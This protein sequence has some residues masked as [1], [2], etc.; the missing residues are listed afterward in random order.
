MNKKSLSVKI[1][2]QIMKIGLYQVLLAIVFSAA[3]MAN[4]IDAQ[5]LLDKKITLKVE[6][7]QIKAIFS[8][9]EKQAEVKFMYTHELIKASRKVT[10]ISSDERLEDVLRKLL[11]PLN[12]SYEVNG[13]RILLTTIHKDKSEIRPNNQS[14]K[15]FA[16]EIK[17]KIIDETGN[18]MPG[19]NIAIK[20]TATG[21]TT[22]A[23]GDYTIN[24]PDE[25]QVL[26][27]S[28]IGYAT[29]EVIIGNQTILNITLITDIKTL[30]E[31]IV[32]GYGTQTQH[33]VTEAI[34]SVT[35]KDISGVAVTGLDQALQGKLAGVQV[36]Q[37]TGEPGGNV[38]IRIRG[39]GSI[40]N[41]NEP[42]YIVDGVPYGTNGPL[43]INPNDIERIDVLKDA[44][45]AAIYGSR[46]TN[47][48]VLVTTKRAKAGKIV[49][50][51]DAYAGIQS[52]Y[53]KLNLL[54]GT[55]FATLANENLMNANNETLA[56]DPN[57]PPK[58][59][60]GMNPAWSDPSKVLNTDWQNSVL[61]TAPIQSY[62]ISISGGTEKSR[63]LLSIG[64]F[65]QGGITKPSNYKRITARLN[66]DYEISQK[67]KVGITLNA[68]FEEKKSVISV[69]GGNTGNLGT[70]TS[71]ARMQ[72]TSLVTTDKNGYFG[73][74]NDGT[75]NTDST[76]YGYEGFSFPSKNGGRGGALAYL[77]GGLSNTAYLYQKSKS[78]LGK[79]QQLLMAGFIE[80][81]ILRGLKL[82][83]SL[84]YTLN[85]GYNTGFQ[86]KSPE[87]I[88]N[89][90]NNPLISFFNESTY[91]SNQWNWV[92]TLSYNKSF[93]KHNLGIIIG[94]DALKNNGRNISVNTSGVAD[95]QQYISGSDFGT[96]TAYGNPGQ[97]TLVSYISRLTYDYAGKYL[98][99]ANLRRDGSSNFGPGFKY[100]T[101][102]SASVGW[103]I[104]EE[105]F[106]KPLSFINELK[107]RASYGIVGN[108]NVRAFQYLNSYGN[109]G[110]N[111]QYTLGSAQNSVSAFFPL[112]IGVPSI[113]WEKSN[114]TNFGLDASFLNSK[115][116]ITADYYIKKISDM[117]GNFPVA[118]YTGVPGGSITKNGFSMENRGLELAI[119][120]NQKVGNV[121][122]S[123]N[124]NFSTLD[125]KVTKLTDNKTG[126]IA[127]DI[128]A[129]SGDGSA[130][131]RT[132]VGERIGNFYGYV[133]DGIIQ[134][135]SDLSLSG[136]PLDVTKPGDRKYKN[137]DTAK[138]INS[139]D[140]TIIGNG[141]PK[142][143]FG[144]SL[145]AEYKGFDVSVLLNGQS[146]VQIANQTR[147]WLYNMR[148]D[149]IQGGITNASADLVNS[150]KG[151]GTSNDLPRNSY[152][153]SP[154]NRLFSTF[155]IENGAF[156]R[157]RNI[158]L[159]YTLP[160]R[161]S[162]K[163]GMSRARVYLMAQNLYTFTKYTGYDPE[164]GSL[165]QDVLKT[166]VDFGRYP[167]PRMFTGGVNFQF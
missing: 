19:V 45:S 76:Y 146:G 90:G 93:D 84:N 4:D 135:S 160:E 108:Q 124:A 17:G 30:G 147:Y 20:G 138:A 75:Y 122:F 42:L 142:Y 27:F 22:D 53:K 144:F 39:V 105:E 88:Q 149:I 112:N 123:A 21:T 96:R 162:K 83:S 121:N 94:T 115:F 111:R 47:G 143:I 24:A 38:S 132:E 44:A 46:G 87:A 110:G 7:Q 2:F 129:G 167:I 150:W 11:I 70:L 136:M 67:L 165:N 41:S 92:N 89:R 120:Y 133:T 80:Y 32:V 51:F 10:L 3:T 54:N 74:N 157:V 125:N 29:Q 101:F 148:Y 34:G 139:K 119:G 140:R 81:E 31:V 95:D 69:D 61:Q 91:T 82:R 131:T 97:S 72:P 6:N 56:K 77:P 154:N 159:G 127:S 151:E 155:N 100:G 130:I 36:T 33:K 66:T 40:N 128:S 9:L 107:L 104:S 65:E 16:L 113:S 5:E 166:G 86:R 126:F 18:P 25:K 152:S 161:W 55:Q 114:Q 58:N 164:I 102:S 109:D 141:L 43:N 103:R 26:V 23:N 60:L 71:S 48:V 118:V 35:S 1:I 64:Y 62:N 78:D 137:L 14:N 57:T 79:S 145:K 117:L 59:L 158:Q 156:L 37:N 52:A 13:N 153:S 98:F 163:V 73:L 28:F 12:I 99:N 15:F 68:S 116:T 134:N 50:N 106:M 8:E 63:S 49:I 85:T